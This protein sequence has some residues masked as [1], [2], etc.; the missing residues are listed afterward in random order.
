MCFIIKIAN[1]PCITG[2]SYRLGVA[3]VI[4]VCKIREK[5]K[6]EKKEQCYKEQ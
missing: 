6:K 3:D 4:G 2:V 5:K 1:S